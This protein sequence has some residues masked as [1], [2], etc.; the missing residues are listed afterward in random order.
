MS[1]SIPERKQQLRDE[2]RAKLKEL[3]AEEQKAL[4][5]QAATLLQQQ[6]PWRQASSVLFYAPLNYE[7]DLRPLMAVALEQNKLV[8]LP[9]FIPDSGSYGAFQLKNLSVDCAPGKFGIHE[10]LESCPAWPLNQLDLVLVPGVGFD[11]AGHRL[12]RGKGFY[13]RLLAE[14]SG[15][16]CGVAFDGQMIAAIPCEPHDVGLDCI[17]TPTRW[18]DVS[19]RRP[20]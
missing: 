6:S 12:G 9:K 15:I 16:R 19:G 20:V 8:A 4:S 2:L 14:V 3:P 5:A 1:V 17:L 13:D 11:F 10:P 7:I 18:L